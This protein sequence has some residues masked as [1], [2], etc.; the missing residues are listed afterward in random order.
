MAR[1]AG[2]AYQV[3]HITDTDDVSWTMHL[4]RASAVPSWAFA[5]ATEMITLMVY[6]MR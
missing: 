1:N 4:P 5:D 2:G 3:R 6:R